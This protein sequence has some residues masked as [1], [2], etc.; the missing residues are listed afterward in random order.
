MLVGK[1]APSL[2][3]LKGYTTENL[4]L[5][6]VK[7]FAVCFISGARQRA[8]LPCVFLERTPKK[9]R[10]ANKLFVVRYKKR[11]ANKL[12]AVRLTKTHDKVFFSPY[13]L[14]INQILFFQKYLSCALI[15]VHGKLMCL[16]C[17]FPRRRALFYSALQSI[18]LPIFP[19]SQIKL[20]YAYNM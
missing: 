6:C 12:F 11:M 8:Y 3:I 18:F 16:S 9:K 1:N 2:T 5:S 19:R 14:Q 7:T 10:T 4:C 13:A 20:L 15:P 17:A